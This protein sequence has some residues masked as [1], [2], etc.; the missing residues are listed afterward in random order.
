MKLTKVFSNQFV[1]FFL[2][3]F[4]VGFF[5][6]FQGQDI[7]LDLLTYHY[8]NG[9]AFIHHR[10]A[11][12]I[13]PAMMQTYMNPYLDVLNYYL[14]AINKPMLTGFML[15]LFSGLSCF[16]LY[17]ISIKLFADTTSQKTMNVLAALFIGMTGA[18]TISLLSTTT[19]DTKVGLLVIM[20]LYFL[21]AGLDSADI[22]QY[23]RNF[24]LAA[25]ISGAAAGLKLPFACYTLGLFVALVFSDPLSK[26]HV[27]SCALFLMF[28]LLGFLLANGY[29]MYF[30][31]QLFHNPFYPFFNNIFHSAYAPFISFNLDA[32]TLKQD[33]MHYLFLPFSLAFKKNSLISEYGMRDARF[34]VIFSLVIISFCT[35]KIP[36]AKLDQAQKLWKL[37]FIFYVTSYLVWLLMFAVYRYA[38]P[39][40]MTSGIVI[41]YLV[42]KIFHSNSISQLLIYGLVSLFLFTTISPDWGRTRF[43][44]VYF[45]MHVPPVSPNARV[46][47]TTR[48]LSYTIP[49]FPK[50]TQFIGMPFLV[51]GEK[52]DSNDKK[53]SMIL[54]NAMN[55]LSQAAFQYPIYTLSAQ[56]DDNNDKKSV[57]ILKKFGFI[58]DKAS[59]LKFTTNIGD[60]LSLCSVR[61]NVAFPPATARE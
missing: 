46:I 17:K 15:S 11:Q 18:G 2:C 61:N 51:L 54:M 43:K 52:L 28:A 59:C 57:N 12:D 25:L 55:K 19:N 56:N 5:S 37:F 48:A 45:S 39:L 50:E 32:G 31:Y 14:I 47:F 30:V 20:A 1:I 36:S 8:Y 3:I 23:L 21:I 41:V 44:E 7:N 42:R 49:F 60:V 10:Y 13:M 29:W 38:L 27:Y 9:Y 6:L 34:A 33:F 26:K 35:V 22:G 53:H 40:E 58:R 24:I 4:S 16:F